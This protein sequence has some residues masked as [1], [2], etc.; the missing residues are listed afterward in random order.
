MAERLGKRSV[1][2]E[3]GYLEKTPQTHLGV[4]EVDLRR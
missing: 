3:K 1:Q 4:E 2:I